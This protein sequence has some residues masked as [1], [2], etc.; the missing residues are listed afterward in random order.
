MP[1]LLIIEDDPL[2]QELYRRLFEFKHYDI[3]T[4]RDGEDG[5]AKLK[6]FTADL[7]LLDI[8]MPIMDGIDMLRAMSKDDQLKNIPV[9][10][11]TNLD[12]DMA[13]KTA[14]ELGAKDYMVK[15]DFTPSEIIKQ[16]ER[17]LQLVSKD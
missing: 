7:V 12:D 1:K 13:V 6:N 9:I 2:V 3:Q 17:Q 4:A 8:M 5:L 15:S 10:M 14:K 11:L 16:V